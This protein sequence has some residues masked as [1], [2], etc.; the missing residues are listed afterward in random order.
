MKTG[1]HREDAVA[2]VEWDQYARAELETLDDRPYVVLRDWTGRRWFGG[3]RDR[4]R[5]ARSLLAVETRDD[6]VRFAAAWGPF[7]E[8]QARTLEEA[9]AVYVRG[10]PPPAREVE[11]AEVLA[12]ARV[13]RE[14]RTR[15]EA[16][17]ENQR[18]AGE[19]ACLDLI[20][21]MGLGFPPGAGIVP[22]LVP[23]DLAQLAAVA[24]LEDMRGVAALQCRNWP[25]PG[26]LR[27]VPP[28]QGERGRV[29]MY[30][31]AKCAD[32][33]RSKRKYARRRVEQ[34]ASNGEQ[35]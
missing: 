22:Q 10:E 11:V 32:R 33:A 28:R 23:R 25:A 21:G 30:C 12:W 9:A 17:D 6:V 16:F 3:R 24:L 19:V 5:V 8:Y 29:P 26:C 14:A 20:R 35:R 7:R 15:G 31:S 1:T 34:E 13:L 18:A 4:Q 27:D 2:D